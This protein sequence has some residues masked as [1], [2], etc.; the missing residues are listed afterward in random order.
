MGRKE[1]SNDYG[2][3][4]AEGGMDETEEVATDP[5]EGLAN[6]NVKKPKK[7]KKRKGMAPLNGTG[8]TA[9]DVQ[10]QGVPKPKSVVPKMD[11][12]GFMMKHKGLKIE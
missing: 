3:G 8:E 4:A 10:A 9:D 12:L 7:K 2:S 11:R 6:P 1:I 5:N